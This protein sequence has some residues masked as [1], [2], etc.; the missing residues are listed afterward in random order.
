M[1]RL[2]LLLLVAVFLVACGKQKY[3]AVPP[4]ATVLILG[5]SVSYGT[6]AGK[7]EDYPTL[8]ASKTGWNIINAGV[9][10]D[11][12]EGG[13]ERLPQLLQE[14][15][16]RLLLVELGGN[17]F[18][19]RVPREQT[20]S[21]L[22]AILSQSK[23]KGIPAVLLAV[24]RPNLFGAAVGNLSDD[25]IYEEIAKETDT[26]IVEDV[27]S[28]VMAKNALK[29]DPIHPN[30][31]GYRHMEEGLREALQELGFLK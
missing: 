3:A 27:L 2:I 28:D 23:A 21:N 30:A 24:P 29:S 15:S 12:T 11:T 31:E 19:R 14:H 17:D 7:G 8:L 20:A 18:L 25:S 22:K 6:G 1:K 5:D 26:P 4:G 13:L 9:P 10:G 16:P